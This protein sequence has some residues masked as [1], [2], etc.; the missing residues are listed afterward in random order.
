MLTSVF[1]RFLF[2][3][4]LQS[5]LQQFDS[6]FAEGISDESDSD[7]N[8]IEDEMALSTSEAENVPKVEKS[9]SQQV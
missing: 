6:N 7:T 2:I 8:S 1:C 5:R 3:L 4:A 9:S